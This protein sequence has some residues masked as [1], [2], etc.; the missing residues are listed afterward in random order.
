M[1]VEAVVRVIFW[2]LQSAFMMLY[3]SGISPFQL[4]VLLLTWACSFIKACSLEANPFECYLLLAFAFWPVFD[5]LDAQFKQNTKDYVEKD[6]QSFWQMQDSDMLPLSMKDKA[7]SSRASVTATMKTS[8]LSVVF[9]SYLLARRHH[10]TP[11]L[12]HFVTCFEEDH[13]HMLWLVALWLCFRQPETKQDFIKSL[14]ELALAHL[15]FGSM[16]GYLFQVCIL[17]LAHTLQHRKLFCCLFLAI[18]LSM[19]FW[20][21]LTDFLWTGLINEYYHD[22]FFTTSF[23]NKVHQITL[24]VT[25]AYIVA[26]FMH[27]NE[28]T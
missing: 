1:E 14:V 23:S 15:C 10:V 11:D 22:E 21:N 13:Q 27:P 16:S 2:L 17:G 8:I 9:M 12:F 3:E 7:R 6:E 5:R 18:Y 19:N 28:R 25:L 24:C 20:V 26:N 4:R